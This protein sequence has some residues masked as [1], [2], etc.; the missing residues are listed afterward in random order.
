MIEI[1]NLQKTY[2]SKV[3]NYDDFS[4]SESGVYLI[5]GPSGTGKTSLLDMLA[6][7]DSSYDGEIKFDKHIFNEKRVNEYVSYQMQG[8]KCLL[9]WKAKEVLSL[10]CDN[11]D[12]IIHLASEFGISEILN[13]KIKNLSEGERQRVFLAQALLKK[14]A[15]TFLDEPTSALDENNASRII[16]IIDNYAKSND[17][18]IILS[19]H[20]S[21]LI[22]KNYKSIFWEDEK[23]KNNFVVNSNENKI[24]F[25]RE[26]KKF[27][28]KYFR[29]FYK[30]QNF[31]SYSVIYILSIIFAF[32]FFTFT[33]GFLW[34]SIDLWSAMLPEDDVIVLTNSLDFNGGCVDY[35][36]TEY[37]A[38]DY[39]Y[40][41]I[42]GHFG[43]SQ[44]EIDYI[45]S[46]D[47]VE[48]VV[49]YEQTTQAHSSASADAY[50]NTLDPLYS[51]VSLS[52]EDFEQMS[53]AFQEAL[54]QSET[55][56]VDYRFSTFY[57]DPVKISYLGGMTDVSLGTNLL[58][59]SYESMPTNGIIIP[60]NLAVLYS[61]QLD[62]PIEDLI[63]KTVTVNVIDSNQTPTT[64]DYVIAGIY[65]DNVENKTVFDL[66]TVYLPY[67]ANFGPGYTINNPSDYYQSTMKNV[68]SNYNAEEF[69]LRY[70]AETF[71]S[72]EAFNQSFGTGAQQIA[73][74][75]EEDANLEYIHEQLYLEF[76]SFTITSK[77]DFWNGETSKSIKKAIFMSLMI[78]IILGILFAL[79]I[80]LFQRNYYKGFR[81][82]LVNYY[83]SGYSIKQIRGAILIETII[84]SLI[85]ILIAIITSILVQQIL[86]N[87]WII[88]PI[89][90]IST[91]VIIVAINV[92]L[93]ISVL[94][95]K[96]KN[97]RN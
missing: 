9:N 7:L 39:T 30:K 75:P 38:S 92:P 32:L 36:S 41:S 61:K 52:N 97:L 51:S 47:G 14:S 20:D 44:E 76:D 78:T 43:F 90:I 8:T 64:Q 94:K 25:S 33:F 67:D 26:K 68:R 95:L 96:K 83:I 87:Q 71:A 17:V 53:P 77:Y 72:E 6:K 89:T 84:I 28:K 45:E 3:I 56:Q 13:K 11:V 88:N 35:N 23:F 29:N 27:A 2:K 62:L 18:V 50:G 59:G 40:Q 49:L 58:Y 57:A 82:D 12:E 4:I 1:K 55:M 19:T 10:V 22:N 16:E 15:V 54:L 24:N 46:I 31:Y 21:K 74:I 86:M 65:D 93:L 37:C 81:A 80:F 69:A 91:I 48:D 60:Y 63:N 34:K 85:A 66:T 79:F 5:I 70:P 73:I 42:P